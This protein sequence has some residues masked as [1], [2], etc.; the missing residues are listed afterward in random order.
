VLIAGSAFAVM[1]ST[2][3]TVVDGFPRAL[4]TR[5]AR[6]HGAESPQGLEVES[7][8][9]RRNY[10]IFAL[11]LG[12]GSVGLLSAFPASAFKMLVDVATTLSFLTAPV[13]A[14]LNHRAVLGAEIPEAKRP[15]GWLLVMSQICV[16]VLAAFA[17]FYLFVRFGLEQ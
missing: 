3:L 4:A 12:V 13:L 15:P 7:G 17:L 1:F 8:A 9:A 10:W 16:L 6:F 2:T 5:V 14:W 11:L